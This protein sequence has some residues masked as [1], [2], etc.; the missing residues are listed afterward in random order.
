M[1]WRLTIIKN[2]ATMLSW[3]CLLG[4]LSLYL[5]SAK[6]YAPPRVDAWLKMEGPVQYQPEIIF[7]DASLR[8]SGLLSV[9]STHV[10]ETDVGSCRVT[11]SMRS[12]EKAA[13]VWFHWPDTH[14]PPIPRPRGALWVYFSMESQGY[15]RNR[16]DYAVQALN[17]SINMLCT[18][19]QASE[20]AATY[21][22]LVERPVPLKTLDIGMNTKSKLAVAVI[23]NCGAGY[24]ARR[25]KA[26][27]FA[28]CSLSFL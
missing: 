22:Y 26:S 4:A 19:D 28:D 1:F 14:P 25:L 9:V 20:I 15:A 3:A 13:V 24:R 7:L 5:V 10:I 11:N 12:I 6:M 18:T 23:S 21:G 27:L 8:I 17:S 16:N 2:K